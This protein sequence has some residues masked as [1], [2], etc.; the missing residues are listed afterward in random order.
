MK[1]LTI[2]FWMFWEEKSQEMMEDRVFSYP[3]HFLTGLADC[4]SFLG[5]HHMKNSCRLNVEKL[6]PVSLGNSKH[7]TE[8]LL[9]PVEET[10]AAYSHRT[11]KLIKLSLPCSCWWLCIM[12]LSSIHIL[13]WNNWVTEIEVRKRKLKLQEGQWTTFEPSAITITK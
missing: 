2:L 9:K 12:P 7:P 6:C 10:M 8:L 11:L 3:A 1:P 5:H 4:W 13:Y